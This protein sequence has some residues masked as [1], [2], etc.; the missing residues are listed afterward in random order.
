MGIKL[1]KALPWVRSDE[2][3]KEVYIDMVK[4]ENKDK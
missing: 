3:I 1:L 2:D 4:T